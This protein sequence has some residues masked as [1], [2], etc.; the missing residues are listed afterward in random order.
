MRCR[1]VW[2]LNCRFFFFSIC[3]G[4][5][6]SPCFFYSIWCTSS[7]IFPFGI[8]S[9]GKRISMIGLDYNSSALAQNQM[10]CYYWQENCSNH[11]VTG[12]SNCRDYIPVYS[13]EPFISNNILLFQFFVN[14]LIKDFHSLVSKQVFT[15]GGVHF[16][17][18]PEKR[19]WTQKSYFK[20]DE[21]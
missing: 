19:D 5:Y 16:L 20:F 11:S 18:A 3:C 8:K 2:M 21:Q 17:R 12:M 6:T 7:Q 4:P 14:L 15:S 10:Q 9:N 1:N 13:F